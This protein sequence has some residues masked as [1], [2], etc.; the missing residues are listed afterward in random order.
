[1]MHPLSEN[2]DWTY[3][4]PSIRVDVSYETRGLGP[5][6]KITATS[7]TTSN[8]CRETLIYNIRQCFRQKLC[9]TNR[10]GWQVTRSQTHEARLRTPGACGPGRNSISIVKSDGQVWDARMGEQFIQVV[11]YIMGPVCVLL[12]P[13]RPKGTWWKEGGRPTIGQTLTWSGT[14]NWF[15]VH[16][17]TVALFVG[18]YRQCYHLILA[19]EADKILAAVD[20]EKVEEV[21]TE[22]S[23]K[24]ALAIVKKT[25][26]WIEV[27]VAPSGARKNYSF[28]LKTW[29]RLIRLQRAIRRHSYEE[30]FDQNFI[31]GWQL[32]NE[33]VGAGGVIDG[34]FGFWGDEEKLTDAHRH[35]MQLGAPRRKVSARK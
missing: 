15:L 13:D 4:Q 17:V 3:T 21:L 22:C 6:P 20:S 16:P 32:V 27:P 1:M 29:R 26:P 12:D 11:D 9:K 5:A 24:K 18:L 25:R 34:S 14:T 23:Q 28:P 19:G 30:A 35:L 8:T 10:D 7:M 31:D 33:N 2:K